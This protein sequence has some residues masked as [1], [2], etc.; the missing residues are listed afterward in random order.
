MLKGDV[1]MRI[2]RIFKVEKSKVE[3][4]PVI[5]TDKNVRVVYDNGSYWTVRE[6]LTDKDDT[7]F[8]MRT[9]K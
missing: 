5:T 3:K 4:I 8:N 6:N 2:H 7:Y 1:F 9:D